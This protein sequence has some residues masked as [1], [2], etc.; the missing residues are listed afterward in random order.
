MRFHSDDGSIRPHEPDAL[1]SPDDLIVR[2]RRPDRLD[3]CA[4]LVVLFE[5][6]FKITWPGLAIE[7]LMVFRFKAKFRITSIFDIGGERTRA[8]T[9]PEDMPNALPVNKAAYRDM[10]MVYGLTIDRQ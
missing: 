6:A 5:A 8:G 3:G 9:I 4:A 1:H 2:N 7:P 10:A